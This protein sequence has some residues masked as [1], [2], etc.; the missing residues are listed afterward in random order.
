MW[1]SRLLLMLWAIVA[2]ASAGAH[3][4]APAWTAAG[5]VWASSPGWQDEIAIFDILL[6]CVFAR[7]VYKGSHAHVREATWVVAVLSL[8]LGIHHM[9]GWLAAARPFHV[10]FTIANFAASAWACVALLVSRRSRW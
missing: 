8:V 2:L 1:M 5:T 3:L 7:L 9:T 6:A 10:A 4:I